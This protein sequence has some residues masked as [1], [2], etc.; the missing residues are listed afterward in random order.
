MLFNNV[1]NALSLRDSVLD[2]SLDLA[3]VDPT[4]VVSTFCLRAAAEK[5]LRGFLSNKLVTNSLHSEVVYC[6]SGS[7]NIGA[8]LA[9][10][11]IKPDISTVLVVVFSPPIDSL[12]DFPNTPSITSLPDV[13]KGDPMAFQDF[14]LNSFFDSKADC[15]NLKISP[16]INVNHVISLYK[17]PPPELNFRDIDGKDNNFPSFEDLEAAIVQ[18]IAC[19]DILSQ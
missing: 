7:R 18:R 14:Y 17:I 10:F 13:I 11:G 12:I 5:A 8:G 16:Q 4:L 6:L 15:S 2:R 3:F 9:N 19:Q 1:K